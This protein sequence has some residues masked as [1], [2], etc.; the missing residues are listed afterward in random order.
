MK[1]INLSATPILRDYY[2]RFPNEN[3]SITVFCLEENDSH[4]NAFSSIGN[5]LYYDSYLA[6]HFN[7]SDE[8]CFACIAHEIGHIIDT[9]TPRNG[10]DEEETML[11]GFLREFNADLHVSE[12]EL[13][14]ELI[15]ALNKM[16]PEDFLTKMRIKVLEKSQNKKPL[17]PDALL[18]PLLLSEKYGFANWDGE[19]TSSADMVIEKDGIP[20]YF[21]IKC[22]SKDKDVFGAGTLTEWKCAAENLGHYF[23][24]IVKMGKLRTLPKFYIYPP[25]EIIKYSTVPPFKIDFNISHLPS[26]KSSIEKQLNEVTNSK[27]VLPMCKWKNYKS[28]D[29]NAV[30]CDGRTITS[31]MKYYYNNLKKE[32]DMYNKREAAIKYVF[33]NS[34]EQ[35]TPIDNKHLRDFQKGHELEVQMGECIQNSIIFAQYCSNRDSSLNCSVVEGIAINSKNEAFQHCWTKIE[36]DEKCC[37]YD[38]THDLFLNDGLPMRYFKIKEH[39]LQDV[40]KQGIWSFSQDTQ[41]KLNA[42]L[43]FEPN[44]KPKK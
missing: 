43:R 11:L 41:D 8:E 35:I 17:R 20:W 1:M 37:E 23:F 18:F 13:H 10:Q 38:V 2:A 25:Q 29:Y 16:C 12:L 24:V 9:K 22:T 21:E 44:A 31:M 14:K 26:S 15:S 33:G 42:Y 40:L 36:K 39:S 27:N 3:N 32:K 7:L 4:D 5:M 30:H 19:E 28:K 6:K 34:F